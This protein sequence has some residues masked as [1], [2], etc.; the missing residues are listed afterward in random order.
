[1]KKILSLF[2]VF[3]M[4]FSVNVYG[5]SI[6]YE[7]NEGKTVKLND[8]LD[9]Q[10]HWAHDT[11]LKVAE[12]GL[13]VGSNGNFMP[14][15][16]I[17]RGDL[18][19]IIDRMLGLKTMSY[20]YFYDLY[21]KDYY[22]ESLLKCVAA[23]YITGVGINEIDPNGYATREQVAVILSRM[24]DFNSNNYTSSTNFKDD[25]KISSWARS[26]VSAMSRLGYINGTDTG[27]VN[28]QSYITRAE[29][30]TMLNNIANTYIPKKVSALLSGT[31]EYKNDFPTNAVVSRNVILT[32]SV[33]NRDLIITHDAGGITLNS[34]Q[35]KGRLLVMSKS[36]ITLNNSN[37]SQIVLLNGK[38]TIS[39]IS[40]GINS[41]RVT[42]NA[43]E[44]TLDNIPN[45]LILESGVRVRV[46]G[47]MYENEST[48]TK[49]YYASDL[50]ADISDE[51]GYV[52]GGPK[53]SGVKFE[54]DM[55][56]T[57]T[58]SNVR[59]T[60]G[61]NNIREIGVIWLEQDDDENAVNPTYK[62]NDGRKIYRSD[63]IDELIEFEVGEVEG[64]CA[65]R[66]Y[67]KDK[68]GL[69]A[70]SNSTIFS[71]YE[72]STTLKI[73]DNN[74]P[75][76][77]DVEVVFRGDSIPEIS[78]IR[79]VYSI[80]E[81][82]SENHKD[83][84]LKLYSDPD[85]E[86]QPDTT[87]Y[88]RY[89]GTIKCEIQKIDGEIV[90][91]PPTAFG[92]IITFKNGTLINRFPILTNAVPEGVSPMAN[93]ETGSAVYDAST[94]LNI[95]NNKITTRYIVPQEIGV[96]YKTS[97]SESISRPTTGASGWERKVS[98]VNLDVNE[99]ETF[100]V[101]I[102]LT[103]KEGYTYYCAYVKT[104]NGYWYGNV[105]KFANDVQG[106]ENGPKLY[107]SIEPN[108]I[109]PTTVFI[110]FTYSTDNSLSSNE[111]DFIARIL[112]NNSVDN[113][114]ISNNYSYF[115]VKTYSS[116]N[117]GYIYIDGL[118]SNSNYLIEL[119]LKDNQNLKSNKIC[120]T[121]ETSNYPK[122]QLHNKTITN[123]TILNYE[124]NSPNANYTIL[125][126]DTINNTDATILFS[127]ENKKLSIGNIDVFHP[128]DLKLEIKYRV[129]ISTSAY[130]KLIV[131]SQ[132]LDLY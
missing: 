10:G 44:S 104:S 27:Y 28:P 93:L 49:T 64:T 20:N 32:D 71:E 33:V 123:E 22:A 132:I 46:N 101:S 103:S 130:E 74:Y 18:A 92:Y 62:K 95:K 118:E 47:V 66:F 26:S 102:P 98:Y 124:L 94:I 127:E 125:G 11:I 8:F 67:V 126:F 36:S 35:V 88:K 77:V 110:P 39:G 17:K 129:P 3:S 4:L 43:S 50:Q 24:F 7:D 82:Y 55:D 80:D 16:P 75:E 70:Y 86:Y 42:L 61:E 117:L 60:A 45:M 120:Y 13:I 73:Y 5:L 52:I 56:N 29:L 34:T 6:T 65:Y 25:N 15:Q 97:T 121:F 58:V 106:D 9:T 12:Y 14:D 37:I 85:A 108:I 87:K 109:S 114:W 90:Y 99:S 30:V 59:I 69:F 76:N 53:I 21:D 1:M 48:R 96:V 79:V 68:D 100:N 89:I 83:I 41:V 51:Q 38:T 105:K 40:N 19:I 2:L 128:E 72:Y 78:S 63:K 113:N 111:K 112:K 23:E 84:T 119:Q 57:I 81:L 107:G 116:E 54:Q 131:C 31:S 115:E 122:Y 91:T